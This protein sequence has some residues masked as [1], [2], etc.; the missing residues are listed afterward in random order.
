MS[1]LIHFGLGL[2]L[3]HLLLELA[4]S[5]LKRVYPFVQKVQHF[6]QFINIVC[7]VGEG[8]HLDDLR[9]DGSAVQDLGVDVFGDITAQVRELL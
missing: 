2:S 7:F 5:R 3:L 1:Q 9:D 6:E 8:P 4:V